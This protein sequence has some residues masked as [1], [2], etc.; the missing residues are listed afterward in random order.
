[1]EQSTNLA[2]ITPL[3]QAGGKKPFDLRH[4]W[5]MLAIAGVILLIAAVTIFVL[6]KVPMLGKFGVDLALAE[7][8]V[9]YR[10]SST[11]DWKAA[12]KDLSLGEN[13]EVRT[14]ENSRA[15]L[16][17]DDGSAIR[18][19]ASS[20]IIL[21]QLATSHVVIQNTGGDVYTR[22]VKS[23]SR[24]FE[25]VTNKTT[26]QS[27]GTGY[28]T[29]NTDK[30]EGV[31]VYHSKV[32][33]LGL[34]AS[35]DVVVEQGEKYY[36]V[37]KDNPDLANKVSELSA[38]AVAADTF[39]QWNSE[40]DKKDFDKELGVLFDLKPPTLQVWSP[41]DGQKTEGGSILVKGTTEVGA[42]ILVNGATVADSNGAFETSVALV[43]GPNAIKVEVADA[44]GNKTVKTVTVTRTTPAPAPEV[45]GITLYGTKVDKGVS[46]S[47]KVNGVSISK[48]FKLVKST[49][50][51][52]TYPRNDYQFL[53]A[54]A[55]SYTWK[56][57]DGK[58]YYFRICA[59]DGDSC[60]NYS[61][62]VKITVPYVAADPAPTGSITLSGAG[63][64]NVSWS[65]SGS[66]YYGFKLVWDNS[67]GPTYP[68]SSATFYDKTATSGSITTSPGTYY[69][70]ICMYYNGG[71]VN[72]SNE[73]TVTVP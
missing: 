2:P 45:A 67:T 65:A 52:P 13:A 4:K 19:N 39:M 30:K 55:R 71:C 43:T 8:T 58:T 59:Y 56:L 7:G 17:I 51:N 73:I 15:I 33:I 48:G 12:P 53:E 62:N 20:S 22:V 38:D 27:Q 25:V 10:L 36:L 63:G 49:A 34:T 35:G 6:L 66:P 60:S 29:Y 1:M 70:R 16:N 41:A 42:K 32:K 47:W 18:L 31:E 61:N 69:V 23:D 5:F 64:S 37:D 46:F 72:Y 44:A 3:L 9:Q 26:Y 54:S 40:E 57:K 21:K 68:G 28:R 50:S 11:A 14:L 24:K